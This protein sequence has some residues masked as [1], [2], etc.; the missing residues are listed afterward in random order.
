MVRKTHPTAKIESIA[1]SW[2]LGPRSVPMLELGNEG[3]NYYQ[4]KITT[5]QVNNS[6]KIFG[7][8]ILILKI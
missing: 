7:I 6:G 4:N 1:G 5:R 2:S 3:T 8:E